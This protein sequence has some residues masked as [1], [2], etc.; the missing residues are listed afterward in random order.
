MAFITFR[1]AIKLILKGKVNILSK[2]NSEI[3]HGAGSV[4]HPAVLVM[5]YYIPR[6][7]KKRR[8]NRMGVFRRDKCCCQYCG[9]RVSSSQLTIDHVK[10]RKMGGETTWINCVACCFSCNNKKAGRTPKMANMRLLHKP[11]APTVNIW[12]EYNLIF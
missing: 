8:Y 12:N 1:K 5:K 10:P 2:W 6:H 4:S 3:T 7:I 9:E 11:F